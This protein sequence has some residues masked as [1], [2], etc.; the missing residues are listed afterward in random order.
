MFRT[1]SAALIYLVLLVTGL[2][3]Y[4]S[5]HAD[6]VVLKNGKKFEGIVTN[7]GPAK[8]TVNIG[9]GLISFNRDQVASIARSGNQAIEASW[10]REYF[11]R[12]KFVPEGLNDIAG[13]F[14]ALESS[15]GAAIRAKDENRRIQRQRTELFDEINSIQAEISDLAATFQSFV[16]QSNVAKYNLLVQQQN[17][18]A[19]RAV[20]IND[21]LQKGNDQATANRQII[22]AYL[23]QLADF[24]RELELKKSA[25]AGP[26]QEPDDGKTQAFFSGIETRIEKYSTEFQ[27][28]EV[29]HEGAQDHMLVKVRLNDRIDGLFLLDTGATYVTLSSAIARTLGLGLTAENNVAVS[30]ANGSSVSAQP[31]ILD[32]M[33]TGDARVT[34]VVAMILPQSPYEGVDGLLGMS[35]LREF[36]IQLDPSNNKLVLQKFSPN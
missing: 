22:S 16:P 4:A 9:L 27:Q 33:Q 23:K 11:S 24:E 17:R 8:V 18:L 13:K 31:V 21:Q 2:L 32:S 6:T 1:H 28:I 7:D 36:T 26:N 10:R 29:P 25:A 12:G 34:G 5:A 20:Q 30:L 15:R 19:S 35:F 14:A 3:P